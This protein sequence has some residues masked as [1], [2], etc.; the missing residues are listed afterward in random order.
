MLYYS[1]MIDKAIDNIKKVGDVSIMV[2]N[3]EDFKSDDKLD[4]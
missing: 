3:W 1:G 2:D 4:S